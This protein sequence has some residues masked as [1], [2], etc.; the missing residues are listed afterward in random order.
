MSTGASRLIEGV[1]L[2][3]RKEVEKLDETDEARGWSSDAVFK[4]RG[5]GSGGG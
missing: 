2:V 4:R 5:G 3:A 1:E